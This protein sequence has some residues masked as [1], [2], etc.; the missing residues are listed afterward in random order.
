MKLLTYLSIVS[1][2]ATI[3]GRVLVKFGD[4]TSPANLASS[5]NPEL[6]DQESRMAQDPPAQGAEDEKP[7]QVPKGSDS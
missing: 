2:F 3:V 5:V 4:L 7:A 1:Y 6:T